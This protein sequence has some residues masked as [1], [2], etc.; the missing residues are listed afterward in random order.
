MKYYFY[1]V[2][3]VTRRRH[4]PRSYADRSLLFLM[5]VSLTATGLYTA[6]SEARLEA[7]PPSLP[8]SLSYPQVEDLHPRDSQACRRGEEKA[9][10]ESDS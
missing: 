3:A 10:G 2:S 8:P 4:A 7:L 1:R 5:G 6:A 9:G